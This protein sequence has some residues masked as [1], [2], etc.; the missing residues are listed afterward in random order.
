MNI[1][2]SET[3]QDVY[4]LLTEQIKYKLS[5]VS[6]RTINIAISG[7]N[8]PI[9]L[10]E[11]WTKKCSDIFDWDN[12]KF[13]WVDERCVSP[14]SNESN[15]HNA[16]ISFIG[17]LKLKPE[18]IF[19]IKGENDPQKEAMRYSEITKSEIPIKNGL[20]SF[21]IIL[22]G[23]GDDGHTASLFPGHNFDEDKNEIYI[24]SMNPYTLQKRI[25]MSMKV[26]NNA[27]SVFFLVTGK[28]KKNIIAENFILPIGLNDYPAAKVR[29]I[30]GELI[31]FIDK[32]ASLYNE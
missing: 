18:N 9:A 26:I 32:E 30:N 8:T 14:K 29:P 2:I 11:F 17:P 20:P 31:Y 23:I 10:F 22:L 3:P 15:Y 13:F 6:G 24:R 5:L 19:R 1:M 25:T 27:S 16:N 12:M 21:D 4:K 7:G 28:N